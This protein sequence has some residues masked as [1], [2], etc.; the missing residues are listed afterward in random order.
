ML[1]GPDATMSFVMT[2]VWITRVIAL[3]LRKVTKMEP[4]KSTKC[5]Y[6]RVELSLIVFGCEQR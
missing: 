4:A 1:A 3:L 6:L 5:T 2:T